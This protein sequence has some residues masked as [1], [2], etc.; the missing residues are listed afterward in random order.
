MMFRR[1]VASEKNENEVCE[2]IYSD[3]YVNKTEIL[4]RDRLSPFLALALSHDKGVCKCI[5]DV[6]N[7]LWV[8]PIKYT[9]EKVI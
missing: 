3:D 1:C 8:M 7:S 2:D 4:I 5:E 9:I 6:L